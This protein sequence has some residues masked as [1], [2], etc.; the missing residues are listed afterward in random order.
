MSD[1]TQKKDAGKSR[2]DLLPWYEFTES[3]RDLPVEEVAASLRFWWAGAPEPLR[4]TIPTRQLD[5]VAKVLAFG[6]AKYAPRGWEVGISYSRVFAAASRHAAALER[7]ELLDAESGLPHQHHFWCNVLF[8]VV[9]AE[10][11]R[12]DLDDRPPAVAKV[13]ASIDA[14]RDQL[15]RMRSVFGLDSEP[16]TQRD[17][18]SE[19]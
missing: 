16:E 3:A 2:H 14:A 9:F 10:R 8:L 6:A 1:P 4:L 11:G 13:K 19:N 18:G 7:G 17:R 15:E 12:T 5:G